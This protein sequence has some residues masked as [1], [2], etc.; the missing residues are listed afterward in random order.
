MLKAL[1]VIIFIPVCM[2]LISKK[3]KNYQITKH[4][5][6]I[7]SQDVFYKYFLSFAT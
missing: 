1:I 4:C 6:M 5:E 7:N 3:E 2:L